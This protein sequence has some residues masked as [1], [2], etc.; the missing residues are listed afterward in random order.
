MEIQTKLDV[1]WDHFLR[2]GLADHFLN[3]KID[4]F[5]FILGTYQFTKFDKCR[6]L[7]FPFQQY[8]QFKSNSLVLQS[9]NIVLSQV[10]PILYMCNSTTTAIHEIEILLETLQ[11]TRFCRQQLLQL[12]HQFCS[13]QVFPGIQFPLHDLIRFLDPS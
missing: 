11:M 1:T 6:L 10:I 7:P 9:Y 5:D 13:T 4:V 3:V 2:W 12:V 8:T